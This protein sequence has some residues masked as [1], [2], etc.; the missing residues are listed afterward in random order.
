VVANFP[1]FSLRSLPIS[2]VFVSAMNTMQNFPFWI[3]RK[4]LF[5]KDQPL[6]PYWLG[7]PYSQLASQFLKVMQPIE[8]EESPA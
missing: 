3:Y 1:L 7:E 8:L 2:L 6:H 4:E 5:V